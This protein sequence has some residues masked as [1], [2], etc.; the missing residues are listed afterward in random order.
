[1][2]LLDIFTIGRRLDAIDKKLDMVL[3][4]VEV[5]QDDTSDILEILFDE[6][7][8]EPPDVPPLWD[9]RLTALGLSR[10]KRDGKYRLHAAWMT[11]N[12]SWDDAPTW[13]RQW[14]KDTLGGD[15]HAFGRVEDS[16]GT[17]ITETF[18]LVWPGGG[19]TRT[20]ESDG[21]ANIPMAGQNWNP[22][23]GPGPYTWF[24][25]SGD[26]LHGLGMPNNHHVSF[27]AV[28]R[29]KGDLLTAK[30]SLMMAVK[31]TQPEHDEPFIF[32][33]GKDMEVE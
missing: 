26:K 22:D 27:F 20:P 21:W 32:V 11:A 30:D 12:G 16:R 1:M 28:W 9:S 10:E 15:H 6:P 7:P 18:G 17:A 5:L 13:A 24:A 8:P 19:D 4:G 25:Y 3:N 2:G 14:Q 33:L 23:N 31:Q 29:P